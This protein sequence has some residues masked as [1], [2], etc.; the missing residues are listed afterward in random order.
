MSRFNQN[1]IGNDEWLTPPEIVYALGVFNLDPCSPKD[2]PGP[3][4]TNHFTVNDN[5]LLLTNILTKT[6]DHENK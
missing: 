3:T 5:G 2:R 6:Y 4:A 1:T